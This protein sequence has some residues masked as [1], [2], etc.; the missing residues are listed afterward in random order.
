MSPPARLRLCAA[1]V[2]V[3][4]DRLAGGERLLEERL[5]AGVEED[6]PRRST[7]PVA[8]EELRELNADEDRERRSCNACR[9]G[10]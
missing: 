10:R 9:P 3:E 2:E 8:V 4:V 1:I 7:R 5:H 6:Y